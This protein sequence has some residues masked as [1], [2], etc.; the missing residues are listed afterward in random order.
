MSEIFRQLTIYDLSNNLTEKKKSKEHA[1]I[2]T[3]VDWIIT[4]PLQSRDIR[5]HKDYGVMEIFWLYLNP[6]ESRDSYQTLRIK[7]FYLYASD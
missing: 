5:K 7:Y 3:T 6:L 2:D 4:L 1:F